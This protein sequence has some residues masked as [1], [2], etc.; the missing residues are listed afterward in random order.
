MVGWR[1]LARAA[2]TFVILGRV[3]DLF[4]TPRLKVEQPRKMA[5]S[6]TRYNL[7]NAENE[8]VATAVE[9]VSRSGLETVRSALPGGSAAAVQTLLLS[10]AD[11]TPLLTLHKDL[12]TRRTMLRTPGGEPIGCLR[13]DRTTRH[14]TLLDAAD[15]TVGGI[16]G[17]LSLRRFVV[18]DGAGDQIALVKKKWAGLAT[19]LL[20]KA[21]RYTVEISRPV[22]DPLRTLVAVSA[23]VIDLLVHET[24]D[25]V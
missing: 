18:S 13:S 24:K 4:D 14:Y 8:L 11:D 9:T 1:I 22:P 6:Q 21:D 3:S 16:V 17:D 2:R 7:F 15:E 10:T 19:E 23:I 5:S 20:T 12:K 25:L